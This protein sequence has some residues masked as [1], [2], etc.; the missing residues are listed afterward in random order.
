[1]L[2]NITWSKTVNHRK[3]IFTFISNK[4]VKLM[5]RFNTKYITLNYW[6]LWCI[7]K[8]YLVK[9][10]HIRSCVRKKIIEI[11]FGLGHAYCLQNKI[12]LC[13]ITKK[14]MC[15]NFVFTLF[16]CFYPI[17]LFL[18]S[19]PSQALKSMDT[20]RHLKRGKC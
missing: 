13:L 11:Y 8:F 1:M 6:G 3:G 7:D 9:F 10:L 12:I 4:I 19:H 5:K 20:I 16:Y 14:V 18:P 15:F 17:L 2:Q